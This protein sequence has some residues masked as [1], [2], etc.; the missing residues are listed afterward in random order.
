MAHSDEPDL[1]ARAL[2]YV[3][4]VVTVEQA[5]AD[6]RGKVRVGDTVW[7]AQGTDAP[8]GARVRITGT[9]GTCLLVEHAFN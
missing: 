9:N 4:R 3:G 1:N 8:Q 7:N 5:I 2:Q 6:G